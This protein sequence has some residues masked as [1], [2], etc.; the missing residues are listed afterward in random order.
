MNP[1][2]NDNLKFYEL[3]SD[4]LFYELCDKYYENRFVP[5]VFSREEV[6]NLLMPLLFGTNSNT[7]STRIIY[8]IKQTKRIL[9]DRL[10]AVEKKTASELT[11]TV[12]KNLYDLNDFEE[13]IILFVISAIIN[14]KVGIIISIIRGSSRLLRPTIQIALNLFTDTPEEKIL[15]LQSLL[16]DSR[17]VASNLLHIGSDNNSESFEPIEDREL[18]IDD[19]LIQYLLYRDNILNDIT[20]NYMN[21]NYGIK[22]ARFYRPMKKHLIFE[23]DVQNQI[24]NIINKY[25]ETAQGIIV[26]TGDEG[27]GKKSVVNNILYALN[28]NVYHLIWKK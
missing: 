4:Y 14:P 15:M 7:A 22:G 25:N 5:S 1:I 19:F 28:K 2:K 16:N 6:D 20:H 12:L 10:S 24:N 18:R 3:Y 8:F 17:L 26:I 13:K 9:K 11:I 23:Q 21:F 27:T